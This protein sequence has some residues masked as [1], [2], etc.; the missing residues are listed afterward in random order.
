MDLTNNKNIADIM[1][2]VL[3]EEPK[4]LGEAD[5]S[6]TQIIKPPRILQ[7]ERRHKDDIELD[8]L[9]VWNAFIGKAVHGRIDSQLKDDK[10]FMLEKTLSIDMCGR[11]IS[12]T[13]DAY[14]I[15]N[16]IVYDHKITQTIQYGIEVKPEY[17]AQLN[18]YGYMLRKHGYTVNGLM[19]NVVYLDWRKAAAKYTKED[20]YP[21]TPTRTIP[22][23]LWT[24]SEVE[25]YLT[26][27]I[28]LHKAN[29]KVTDDALVECTDAEIWAKP[30]KY[31]VMFNGATRATRLTDTKEEALDYIKYRGYK[32][33][34]V[35]IEERPA[36]RT[37]CENYCSAAP[38][39][40]VYQQWL[41]QNNKKEEPT[42]D[43]NTV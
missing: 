42:D 29:E 7:L 24:D 11:K 33:N 6:V 32:Q 16:G 36:A 28:E 9:D 18:I 34:A 10:D 5:Y 22:V 37:R 35:Y 23:P 30:T 12:G 8:A 38:F 41:Q 26:Y 31:A 4:E 40:N 27:R 19:L 20:K 2:K 39:C 14:D 15:S 43:F 25:T 21:R 3:K 17:E 13:F 1:L